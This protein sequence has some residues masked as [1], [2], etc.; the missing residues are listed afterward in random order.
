MLLTNRIQKYSIHRIILLYFIAG[1]F[2]IYFFDGTGDSGDSIMH[3]LFARY[4]PIHPQLYF[5]HWAKPFFVLLA[6]P[7]AQFGF[8][9]IKV[10][11]LLVSCITLFQTCKMA[12]LL[13]LEHPLLAPL[14]L[15][16]SPLNYV[17]TFSGLTEPLFAMVLITGVVLL[18]K[19]KYLW[20][21]VILSFLPFVRSEGLVVLLIIAVYILLKG[22]Y[23]F[24]PILLAGHLA[25]AIAGYFVYHDLLWVFNKIPY[26]TT[27]SVYGS[28]KLLHFVSKLY[29]VIGLPV[30]LLFAVGLIKNIVLH[31]KNKINVLTSQMGLVLNIALGFIVAHSMFWYL[32]IFNSMGLIRV[33]LCVTP[34]IAVIALQGYN[35]IA[36]WVILPKIALKYIQWVALAYMIIFPFTPNHAAIH[37]KKD[38]MLGPKQK[39]MQEIS[40]M[41]SASKNKVNHFVY[42]APGMS[43]ALGIDHFDSSIRKELSNEILDNLEPGDVLIW[44]KG[45]SGFQAGIE[46]NRLNKMPHLKKLKEYYFEDTAVPEF[47]VFEDKEI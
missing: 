33:M 38:M 2:T 42:N 12:I 15:M 35:A 1:L 17:L 27:N 34:F 44:D 45:F 31:W 47:A 5:D 11:N 13:K 25:Y 40:T 24:L 36:Q 20:A 26:A 7:F 19:D 21:S 30:Y 9:G 37:F 6:S 41:F 14:I 16:F 43:W 32:G 39:A 18:L 22:K 46:L 4:A 10:F 8:N 28:G 3:Y 29:Y 23:R